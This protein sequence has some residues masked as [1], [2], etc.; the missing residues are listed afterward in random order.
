MWPQAQVEVYEASSAWDVEPPELIEGDLVEL[1]IPARSARYIDGQFAWRSIVLSADV[2]LWTHREHWPGQGVGVVRVYLYLGL[3]AVKEAALSLATTG[4]SDAV[5]RALRYLRDEVA[6][7]RVEDSSDPLT[8][9]HGRPPLDITSEF[10][11]ARDQFF[12][13]SVSSLRAIAPAFVVESI[14]GCIGGVVEAYLAYQDLEVL[15]REP[16]DLDYLYYSLA[17]GGPRWGDE[18]VQLI[19]LIRPQSPCVWD[20]LDRELRAGPEYV[21]F[22][23][24]LFSNDWGSWW[25]EGDG[26]P[27]IHGYQLAEYYQAIGQ[28]PY[29]VEDKFDDEGWEREDGEDAW[30]P[31]WVDPA[32][33]V[34][35]EEDDT[36]D[37]HF[38]CIGVPIRVSPDCA[39]RRLRARLAVRF[40]S[41][42]RE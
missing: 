17:T 33:E 8:L 39:A 7:F 2:W 14:F 20:W 37:A 35:E 15:A 4:T 30:E 1:T 3:D 31:D 5:S 27:L 12:P 6:V 28:A 25:S 36:A 13:Y 10:V 16:G 11:I 23:G 29:R 32:S 34:D 41:R 9:F 42:V 40:G 21:T 18:R 24:R 26:R 19:E 22:I 38:A